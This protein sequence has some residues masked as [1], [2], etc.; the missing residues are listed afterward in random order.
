VLGGEL[1]PRG[2]RVAADD[3]GAERAGIH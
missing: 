3:S 1:Q 2:E